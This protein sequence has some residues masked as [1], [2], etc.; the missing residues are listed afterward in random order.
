MRL[1]PD[2]S[3][4]VDSSSCRGITKWTKRTEWT[5]KTHKT[6]SAVLQLDLAR[7][8][9]YNDYKSTQPGPTTMTADTI[10][11]L[12]PFAVNR[13]DLLRVTVLVEGGMLAI[14]VLMGLAL[15]IPFWVSA[16]LD[17][18]G[19]ALGV[20]A[21]LVMLAGASALTESTFAFAVRMRRDMD[22]FLDLFRGATVPDFLFISVLAGLGEE[23]LFRGVIQ[24][25]LVGH[26][27]LPMAIVV[28]SVLFGLAHYISKTY[29][30]FAAGLGALFGVLYAWSGNI[31]VPMIA[32]ATYDFVALWYIYRKPGRTTTP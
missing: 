3:F 13:R 27:G 12:R 31:A 15:A 19:I 23:A 14:A 5:Y 16:H 4:F 17:V 11:K 8:S 26:I 2:S 21:G 7:R 20:V 22:R 10:E 24:G 30:V 32:H 25:G 9:N 28:S 18:G 1:Q 6:H 29:V